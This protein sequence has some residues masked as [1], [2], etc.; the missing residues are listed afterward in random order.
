MREKDF[1][2]RRTG[3]GAPLRLLLVMHVF[4]P[5]ESM[6]LRELGMFHDW[7][8]DQAGATLAWWSGTAERDVEC[9]WVIHVIEGRSINKVCTALD[10]FRKGKGPVHPLVWA[11]FK[12]HL[13]LR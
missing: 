9:A 7:G 5:E 10:C 11:A 6:L 12:R 3:I 1:P 2:V 4:L 13:V 8:F